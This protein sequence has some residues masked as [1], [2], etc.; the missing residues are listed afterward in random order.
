MV[1]AKEKSEVL[2]IDARNTGA[3]INRTQKAFNGE[4]IQRLAGVYH[5]WR[6]KDGKY[7]DIASF[8]KSSTLEEIKSHDY[9]LTPGRYVGARKFKEDRLPFEKRMAVHILKLRDLFKE[10]KKIEDRLVSKLKGIGY[11]L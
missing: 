5:A 6:S 7:E 10:N 8:C 4:D 9:I 11:E 1:N 2:F 3:M